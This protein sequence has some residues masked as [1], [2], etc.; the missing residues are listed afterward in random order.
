MMSAPPKAA[1]RCA[2][3]V[4][5]HHNVDRVGLRLFVC[6]QVLV[7]Q[8]YTVSTDAPLHALQQLVEGLCRDRSCKKFNV[9]RKGFAAKTGLVRLLSVV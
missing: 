2:A 1:L 5:C 4:A 8:D 7:S 9:L 3:C 6:V